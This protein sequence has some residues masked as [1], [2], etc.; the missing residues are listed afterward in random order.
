MKLVNCQSLI[1]DSF[2]LILKKLEM[3]MFEKEAQV[4]S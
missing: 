1:P 4:I 3:I 2:T